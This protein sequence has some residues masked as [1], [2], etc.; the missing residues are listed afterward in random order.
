MISVIIPLYNKEPIIER[1]L[2]SV[3]SQDYD[4]FE[5][6]VVNDGSTDH[7]A[8]IVRSINDPRIRLIEQEN[9][10]PS[11]ARNTGTKNAR[12]E[13]IVFLDADDELLPGALRCFTDTTN[14]HKEFEFFCFSSLYTINGISKEP[15]TFKEGILRNPYAAFFLHYYSPRTGDFVIS[16]RVANKC[17][18]DENIR[19]FEDVEFYFRVC[20]TTKIYLTPVPVLIENRDFASASSARKDL[21]EDFVGHLDF[22]GKSFW[23]RLSLFKLYIGERCHYMPTINKKYPEFTFRYD[24]L[25]LMKIISFMYSRPILKRLLLQLIQKISVGGVVVLVCAHKLDK[26]IRND[27]VYSAIQVGAEI[28]P[29]IDFGFLKDNIGENVSSRNPQWSELTALYWGWKNLNHVEYA[30]LSHYRRYMDVDIK[31]ENI[32]RLMNGIDIMLVDYYKATDYSIVSKGLITSLSQE[33]FWLYIDTVL[34]VHPDCKEALLKYMY[35]YDTFVPYTMFVAKKHLYDEFCEFLFPVIFELEK[36]VLPH[37]YS[38]QKRIFG[39]FGE[40]TLGLFV[41]YKNLSY[42]TY[43]LILSGNI[44]KTKNHG[45][46]RYIGNIKRR[47]ITKISNGRNPKREFIVPEDV[48]TGFRADGITLKVLGKEK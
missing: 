48:L 45:I 22:K 32:D 16:R 43:N 28:H 8:D 33:D 41:I 6:V 23:E 24:M 31:E 39:Y 40:W 47:I 30:G 9:G 20:K 26:F 18:F 2:Q 34:Y 25:L 21:E 3:L 46:R 36:R 19:R 4:D 7:S 1:S 37:S 5:V 11:K 27:G 14:R 42:S 29:D 12:G 17:L 10:G 15:Y 35:D 13:W 44:V 38:R